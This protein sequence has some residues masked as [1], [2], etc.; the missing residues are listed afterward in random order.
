MWE[1]FIPS[2][3]SVCLAAVAMLGI[4]WGVSVLLGRVG[5]E[6]WQVIALTALSGYVVLNYGVDNLAIHLGGFPILVAYGMMYASL[7]LAVV[8]HR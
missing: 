4:C 1:R 7:A 8:A 2:S 3:G 5:L 6:L